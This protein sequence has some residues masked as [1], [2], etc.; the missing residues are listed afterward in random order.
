M[1]FSSIKYYL[2]EGFTGLFKNRLMTVAS[3]A[4]VAACL[5]ITAFSYCFV[6]NVQYILQQL[7]EEIGIV[8]FLHD[9]LAMEEVNKLNEDM[10]AIPHVTEVMYVSPEDGLNEMKEDWELGEILDSFQ[11]EENP[12]SNGFKISV[13]KIEN[14]K[15]VLEALE[16][17]EGVRTIKNSQTETEFLIKL[18]NIISIAGIVAIVILVII[19]IVIIM[20]TI[21]ISVFTRRNEINI[22]KYVGATDWFIRWPFIIEGALIG[23]VGAILPLIIS[24]FLYGK[25]L[26]VLNSIDIIKNMVRLRYTTDVFST[27]IPFT[28]TGGI[29][30]GVIGSVTSIRKYLKV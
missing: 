9:D 5:F 23:I 3:V 26:D 19:S 11:G 27:L 29:L 8:C 1:K 17:L 6:S 28:L 22:M 25:S 4:T 24:W 15:P 14:Q 2:K 20:N 13:D 30:I 12:L 7:E 18:N 16:A 21:K 10:K